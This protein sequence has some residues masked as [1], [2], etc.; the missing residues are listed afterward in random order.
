[1]KSPEAN[2]NGGFVSDF[3]SDNAPKGLS[4]HSA[5]YFKKEK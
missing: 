4:E 1:M 3:E 5:V 2:T